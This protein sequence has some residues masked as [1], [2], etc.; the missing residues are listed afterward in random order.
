MKKLLTLTA[1]GAILAT[2][3]MAV[4]KCVALSSDLTCTNYSSYGRTPDWFS[5][6]DNGLTILGVAF[7]SYKQG[8]TYQVVN[9]IYSSADKED[10]HCWCKMISPAIS[11]WVYTT[12][13][14]DEDNCN[15]FCIEYCG[16]YAGHVSGFKTAMFNSLS[17]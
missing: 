2:P 5:V 1:V 15:R 10:I 9:E 13:G 6:F 7:C 16:R 8:T 11:K 4:Q 3:A 14:L 12:A 17:D